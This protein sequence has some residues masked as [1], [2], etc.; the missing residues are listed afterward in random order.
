MTKRHY[1]L[2]LDESGTSSIGSVVPSEHKF[3]VLAGAIIEDRADKEMSA[4]LSHIKRRYDLS[5]GESFHAVELFEGAKLISAPKA[6]KVAESLSEFLITFPMKLKVVALNRNDVRKAVGAPSNYGFKGSKDHKED[7]E[8]GYEILTRELIFW[9][10][11]FLK[12]KQ[13]I[14]HIVAESRRHNDVVV[15]KT[16]LSAGESN[17]FRPEQ[18]LLKKW[19]EAA[20]SHVASI[21]FEN[22]KGLEGGLE[23]VDI[24]SY[25]SRLKLKRQLNDNKHRGTVILWD[26]VRKKME[27][28]QIKILNQ[29]GFRRVAPDR[30]YKVAKKVADRL[31]NVFDDLLL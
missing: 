24:T 11:R 20:K 16:F 4:Y 29:S 13:A 17:N 25:I 8:V 28:R 15:L 12:S 21:T 18:I 1:L 6:M 9:F 10:A 2:Y 31:E 22:K 30:I 7:K 23:I 27:E 26:A 19:S 5:D 14:G 3:F